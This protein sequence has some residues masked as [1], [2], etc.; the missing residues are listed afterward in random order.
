MALI[1]YR[2]VHPKILDHSLLLNHS[3]PTWPSTVDYK[4][5]YSE[6][7]LS[8]CSI[9]LKHKMGKNNN[10]VISTTHA[11]FHVFWSH[12]LTLQPLIILHR[13][14]ISFAY[15]NIQTFHM[16]ISHEVWHN[17]GKCHLFLCIS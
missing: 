8:C 3:K 14:Q 13:S 4:I 1:Q 5:R 9:Q 17:D 11:L 7:S 12:P 10:K 2:N 6:D 15:A 16:E